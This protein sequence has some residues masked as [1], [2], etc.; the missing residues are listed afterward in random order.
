MFPG[1][2]CPSPIFFQ[3]DNRLHERGFFGLRW[4]GMDCSRVCGDSMYG[5][6]PTLSTF[7]KNRKFRALKLKRWPRPD[8]INCIPRDQKR[9]LCKRRTE[10]H[11]ESGLQCL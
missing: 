4:D 11:T 10:S 2:E 6:S 7:C 8:R 9:S 1:S 3:D 5:D